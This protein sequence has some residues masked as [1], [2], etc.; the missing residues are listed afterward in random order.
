[1][2]GCH[3]LAFWCKSQD[4]IATS[5]AV[6]ELKASCKG[7]SELLGL[8]HVGEFLRQTGYALDHNLDASA[9]KGILLR[10]G[11]GAIKHLSVRQLWTQ[12]VI[13]DYK[14]TVHKIPRE[15][16][17]ADSMCSPGSELTMDERLTQLGNVVRPRPITE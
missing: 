13:V 2:R 5:S 3:T 4:R 1:M 17:P 11:A 7:L 14:I 12:E 6:A 10:Q 8:V 15:Q 9:T 16:N